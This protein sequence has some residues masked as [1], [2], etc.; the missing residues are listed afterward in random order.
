[1]PWFN[2]HGSIA[3]VYIFQHLASALLLVYP[4]MLMSCQRGKYDTWLQVAHLWV[5]SLQVTCLPVSHC[6]LHVRESLAGVLTSM[7]SCFILIICWNW[8][9]DVL[10]LLSH[11]KL[12]TLRQCEEWL[13]ARCSH[14]RS[15]KKQL[16]RYGPSIKGLHHS[17][18]MFYS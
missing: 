18:T 3:S 1:M 8:S 5:M 6:K 17:F 16:C 2:C 10:K 4:H 9:I 11:V 14:V 15:K 7:S 13:R 12:L